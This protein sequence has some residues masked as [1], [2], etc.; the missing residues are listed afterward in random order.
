MSNK[1]NIYFATYDTSTFIIPF[2]SFLWEKYYKSGEIIFMGYKNPEHKNL[3]PRTKFV[4]MA[5]KRESFKHWAKYICE[6]FKV[7]DDDF[8]VFTVD[9]NS[10][11]GQSDED[12]L[13]KAVEYMKNNRDVM[14]CYTSAVSNTRYKYHSP[15]DK[16]VFD[17]KDYYIYEVGKDKSHIINL[18]TNLWNKKLLIDFL[19]NKMWDIYDFEVTGSKIFSE[20]DK[21]KCIGIHRKNIKNRWHQSVFSSTCGHLVSNKHHKGRYNVYGMKQEDINEGKKYMPDFV[22]NNL[23]KNNI[24]DKHW[25][26]DERGNP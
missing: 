7:I 11:I 16:I 6:Y 5:D 2:M 26:N 24:I 21:Y 18:Q 23:F 10:I 13:Q 9:D 3:G 25:D 15:N 1:V 14:L 22:K 20:Q 8:L 17:H 19:D 4:S 12:L